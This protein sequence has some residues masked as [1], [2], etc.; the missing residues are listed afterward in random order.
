[1]FI[2]VSLGF[3]IIVFGLIVYNLPKILAKFFSLY[4]MLKLF[5]SPKDVEKSKRNDQE[6]LYEIRKAEH[7]I[8]VDFVKRLGYEKVV[9]VDNL[10]IE[11]DKNKKIDKLWDLD[12]FTGKLKRVT[13]TE[14]SKCPYAEVLGWQNI[15]IYYFR[16]KIS[17][18]K[19]REDEWDVKKLNDSSNS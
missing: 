16:E 6:E 17:S 3:A 5:F 11:R 14:L 2:E 7:E 4:F 1:M 18:T 8:R 19:L 10:W 9:G 13:L 12:Y 15:D